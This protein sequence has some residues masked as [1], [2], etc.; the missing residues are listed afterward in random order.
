[1]ALVR[2]PKVRHTQA[3]SARSRHLRSKY[4]VFFQRDMIGTSLEQDRPNPP[5][6]S[7]V[8]E[9][10]QAHNLLICG[11]TAKPSCLRVRQ[12]DSWPKAMNI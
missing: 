1:M 12:E 4:T 5:G 10:I 3:P 9:G 8:Q 11:Q 7:L 2:S 6:P